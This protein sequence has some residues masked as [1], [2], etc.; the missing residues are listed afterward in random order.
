MPN[1]IDTIHGE[2]HEFTNLLPHYC[3]T[4]NFC[5]AFQNLKITVQKLPNYV[6]VGKE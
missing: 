1:W 3:T 4:G 2:T 6:V 5:I